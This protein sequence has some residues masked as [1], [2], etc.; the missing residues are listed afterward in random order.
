MAQN[1]LRIIYDN[2]IDSASLTA[3]TA[4]G[5]LPATNLQRDQK[6]LVWRSTGTSATLTATWSTAQ[7]LSGVVLPFCNLSANATIRVRVY[8]NTGDTTP[9]RDTGTVNARAYAPGD[10]WGGAPSTSVNAYS[11]G[12]GSYA[13]C[14]F[15]SAVGRKLEITLTDSGN[16]SGYLEAGRLVCGAYWS[17]TY[18]TNFGV[19]IGY[20]DTSTQTRT[21]SGN[22]VTTI[23]PT[24]RTLNFDLQWLTDADRE[25]MLSI[26]RG[27]G[28]RK[29]LF[30]SVFPED[31]SAAKEQNYQ[32]YGKMSGL[33]PIT[34]PLYTVYSSSLSLEEI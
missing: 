17:P 28:L 30:V 13:R 10:I 31:A 24:H 12:G 25:R 1:N 6:G 7:T 3:S 4:A 22:L 32:L 23:K 21:E 18:N 26:L 29:P 34:H 5:G 20:V 19:G 8:T 14:W 27:N 16:P 2:V 11:F 15:T 33:N 9:V